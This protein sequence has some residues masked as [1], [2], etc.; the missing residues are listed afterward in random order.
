[1]GLLFEESFGW[2]VGFFL[3]E[4]FILTVYSVDSK[5]SLG[6]DIL[7][8][9]FELVLVLDLCKSGYSVGVLI[10]SQ[11]WAALFLEDYLRFGFDWGVLLIEVRW[12]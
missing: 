8:F 12:G 5:S 4:H 1:M 2:G 10:V 6:K 7:E 9:S 11:V 3:L